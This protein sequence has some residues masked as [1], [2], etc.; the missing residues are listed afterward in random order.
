ML[1]K[2]GSKEIVNYFLDNNVL[3]SSSALDFFLSFD[4]FISIEQFFSSFNFSYLNNDL[5]QALKENKEV[6]AN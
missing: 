5:L 1:A 3:L 6:D 4:D 2:T